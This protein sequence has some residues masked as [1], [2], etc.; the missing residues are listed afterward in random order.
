MHPPPFRYDTIVTFSN[1]SATQSIAARHHDNEQDFEGT[2][3]NAPVVA[4]HRRPQQGV[5]AKMKI[6]QTRKLGEQ[7][8]REVL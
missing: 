3:T 8:W 2:E 4:A 1:L 6:R 5:A 7:A